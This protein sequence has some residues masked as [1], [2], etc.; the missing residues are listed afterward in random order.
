MFELLGLHPVPSEL[1]ELAAPVPA[2]R[3]L[4]E[5]HVRGDLHCHTTWSDG[6]AGV[7]EMA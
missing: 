6:R 4:N 7:R 2:D 3:L 5:P 1:R